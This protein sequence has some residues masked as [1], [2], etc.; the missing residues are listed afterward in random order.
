MSVGFPKIS[1][2]GLVFDEQLAGPKQVDEAPVAGE[3]L[4][5]F[6]I[7]RDMPAAEPEDAEELV[8]ESLPLGGFARFAFPFL[9]E[10]DGAVANLIP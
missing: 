8:P 10:G 9:A 1:P 3:F 2:G 6:L 7:E 4:D 5:R